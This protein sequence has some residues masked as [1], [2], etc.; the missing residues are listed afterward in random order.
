[1]E[2]GR[3][4]KEKKVMLISSPEKEILSE[5]GDRFNQGLLYIAS[6]LRKGGHQVEVSDLNHDSY[7]T[8]NKRIESMAPDYVGMSVMSPSSY[9]AK[10][11]SNYLKQKFPGI[12]TIAGGP[13]A[14]GV[15]EHLVDDF[16]YVVRGEGEEAILDIVEGRSKKG[17][18]SAPYIKN[19]E[20]LA[21]PAVDLLQLDDYG[22]ERDD[23]GKRGVL[24]D[25]S[26]GC[27]GNCFFCTKDLRGH[28]M[29]HYSLENLL[30]KMEGLQDAGF[31]GMYFTDDCFT[32]NRQKAIDLMD[33]MHDRSINLNFEIM[34]RTDCVDPKLLEKMKDNGLKY[35]SY[36]I[37]H[38]DESVF[39][40]CSVGSTKK[41]VKLTRDL[42]IKTAGTFILNLPKATEKSM[43][44]CLDFAMENLDRAKFFGLQ[45]YPGTPLWKNPEK[46]GCTIT[47]TD[48]RGCLHGGGETNIELK[49]MPKEKTERI[50]KDI[51]EKWSKHLN[52]K[53]AWI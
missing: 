24:L 53:V 23:I 37:E 27:I 11:H 46:F 47:H 36:G 18:I 43:Y 38:A 45:A 21:N 2:A 7:K 52:K 13:H 28:G 14:T 6:S 12:Q 1:M 29:R 20:T 19:L 8:L 25:T 39:H 51:R 4:P 40:K 42:G 10:D 26:R 32:A 30:D 3:I 50:I 34:T 16:D 9:W 35:V 33:G 5:A 49:D 31:D 22:I 41:A 15:P 17:I 44:N 48:Y